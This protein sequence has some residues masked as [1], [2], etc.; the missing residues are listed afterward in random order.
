MKSEERE[1]KK[2]Q[3]YVKPQIIATYQKKDL[4]ENI[5]ADA[6]L[7]YGGPTAT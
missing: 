1:I 4:E 7:G 2:K 5:K 3:P 6:G